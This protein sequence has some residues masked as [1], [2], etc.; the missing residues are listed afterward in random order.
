[1]VF[2]SIMKSDLREH[3]NNLSRVMKSLLKDKDNMVNMIGASLH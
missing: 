2:I 1:M 3:Q